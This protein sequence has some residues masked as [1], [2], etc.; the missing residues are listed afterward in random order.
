MKITPRQE[1]ELKPRFALLPNG[2]YPFT[3]MESSEIQSKSAKNPGKM[4]FELKL[5]VHG[6]NGDHHIYSYFS[7]WFNEFQLRHFA[8]TTGMLKQYESGDL[9]GTQNKFQGKIGYVK[10]KTESAKGNFSAKNAVDDYVVREA[11]PV[12]QPSQPPQE[13]NDVP[14]N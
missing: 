7:D 9:D 2:T 6:P 4:M 11:A 13:E 1:N 10:I 3:V 14:F 12:K 5:N 8:A